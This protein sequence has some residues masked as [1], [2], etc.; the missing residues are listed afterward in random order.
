M[1]Y[2]LLNYKIQQ[3]DILQDLKEKNAIHFENKKIFT[4]NI[5]CHCK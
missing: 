4:Y 3:I 2:G 5:V 1:I